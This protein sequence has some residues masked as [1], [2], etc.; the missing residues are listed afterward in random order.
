MATV[1]IAGP[2]FYSLFTQR[3]QIIIYY[4]YPA[5]KILY[6]TIQYTAWSKNKYIGPF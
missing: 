4:L 3:L 2:I 1:S 6:G 5:S